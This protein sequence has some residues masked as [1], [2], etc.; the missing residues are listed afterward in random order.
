VTYEEINHQTIEAGKVSEIIA[1]SEGGSF[2]LM[3]SIDIEPAAALECWSV[4]ETS[5]GHRHFC[6][7]TMEGALSESRISSPVIAFD[8]L[9]RRGKTATGRVYQLEGPAGQSPDVDYLWQ[10]WLG[11]NG[12]STWKDVTAELAD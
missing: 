8:A 6:G 11:I 7:R 10:R 3:K 4:R 1:L 2:W 5:R 9:R 12:L